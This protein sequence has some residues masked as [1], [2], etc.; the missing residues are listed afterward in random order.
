MK[1]FLEISQL[2]YDEVMLLVQRALYFKQALN[3]PQYPDC[4]VANLFYENSTRTRISFELAA[5]HLDMRLIN[6]DLHN[7]SEKKGEVIEDTIHTLAAMGVSTFVIRHSQN[8]LP[9]AMAGAFSDKV[10][11]VNAGDGTNSHP[12]QALLDLMTIIECKAQLEKLKI[13]IVG[14]ILH[15][16]VANSLQKLCA[17][18]GVGDL[19]LVSP[20]IW[21]PRSIQYGR[22]SSSLD[23]EICDADVVISLRVQHERLPS[24]L[25]MDMA[26]YH[27]DYSLTKERI[28]RA[29]KDVMIMHPGPINRGVEID[30]DVADGPRSFILEQVKNGVFMRMAIL[31]AMTSS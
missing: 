7:S 15:S 6:V 1:H 9:Q 18:I 23:D 27:R 8:G 2:S 4:I 16:R 31:E 22:V 11:I 25:N 12:S 30:S 29:K 5:K 17:L 24:E 28:K 3:Y 10:H 26:S 19:V 13:V 20:T 21:Q 14:N